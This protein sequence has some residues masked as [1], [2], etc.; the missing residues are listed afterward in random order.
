[1]RRRE[2][3][4]IVGGAAAAWPVAAQAQQP[5]MPVIGFL[6]NGSFERSRDLLAAFHQG[7]AKSGYIEG[8]NLAIEYRWTEGQIEP[9][10]ALAAELVGRRVAII[11]TV[12]TPAALAAK[13]A[14][15]TIPIIFNFGVDPVELGLV[16]SLAHPGGNITGVASLSASLSGKRLELLHELLPAAKSIAYLGN[17]TSAFSKLELNAV[18]GAARAIGVQLLIVEASSARDFDGAF[19]ALAAADAVMISGDALFLGNETE[20]AVRANRGAIPAI[21]H[22]R[23]SVAKGGLMSYGFRPEDNWRLIGEYAGR[24]LNGERPS[25]LPIQQT[26]HFYLVINLRTAKTLGLIIP[27]AMLGRADE[28]IE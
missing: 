2:F 26:T 14:T 21:Y 22:F 7:L 19:K 23:Q 3:I 12:Y 4:G 9:L 27:P 1:M 13:A 18:Q 25:N 20:I 16:Q 15:Q 28:V 6:T 24:I 10:P 5:A 11:V 8:R 17:P